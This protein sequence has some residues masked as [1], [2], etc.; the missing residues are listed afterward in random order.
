MT[1]DLADEVVRLSN[2]HT[3]RCERCQHNDT[4]P[5]GLVLD[6]LSGAWNQGIR[7]PRR[8]SPEAEGAWEEVLKGLT[9]KL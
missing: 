2:D 5:V 6:A 8:Y 9:D 3:D 7:S 4:C 1:G